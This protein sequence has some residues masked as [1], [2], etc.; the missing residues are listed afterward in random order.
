MTLDFLGHP[1]Y[2]KKCL[3]YFP[4]FKA[5]VFR[6]FLQI[7]IALSLDKIGEKSLGYSLAKKSSLGSLERGSLGSL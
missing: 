7:R 3:D 4:Y 5:L 1:T 2:Q 6:H